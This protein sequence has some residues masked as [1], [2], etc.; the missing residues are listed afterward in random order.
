M[1]TSTATGPVAVARLARALTYLVCAFVL[2]APAM[3]L[4]GFFLLLSGR[5][6]E[7]GYAR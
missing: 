1:D 7:M 5:I 3:L 2:V 6:V 4:F